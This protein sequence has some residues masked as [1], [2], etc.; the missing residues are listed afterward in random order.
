MLLPLV[1][2]LWATHSHRPRC[3]AAELRSQF[4]ASLLPGP[5]SQTPLTGSVNV[6]ASCFTL[7]L[8]PFPPINHGRKIT[9][10]SQYRIEISLTLSFIPKKKKFTDMYDNIAKITE[11]ID[12]WRH[13][14]FIK[15]T[16]RW[17]ASVIPLS[18]LPA[19]KVIR[20]LNY[21]A[22]S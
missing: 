3:A 18:V 19:K 14:F 20:C 2:L 16:F 4:P 7:H 12:P 8:K 17:A 21:K 6:Q 1:L 9:R 22:S 13:V 5:H 10:Q 15:T 11:V